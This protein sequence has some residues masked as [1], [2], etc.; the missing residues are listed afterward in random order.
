MDIES[1]R[2]QADF[3][4][5]W[6]E[7][8][9]QALSRGGGYPDSQVEFLVL[10]RPQSSSCQVTRRSDREYPPSFLVVLQVALS[11]TDLETSQKICSCVRGDVG[12]GLAEA[13]AGLTQCHHRLGPMSPTR[14]KVGSE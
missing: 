5:T 12:V 4:G 13:P 7:L 14:Q 8:S 2:G 11:P 9:K 1:P 3:G 6:H 10:V